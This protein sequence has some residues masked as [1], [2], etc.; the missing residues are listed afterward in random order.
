MKLHIN[1][2]DNPE[3]LEDLIVL[4]EKYDINLEEKD[5]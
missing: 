5:D 1:T 4:L 3:L 2:E